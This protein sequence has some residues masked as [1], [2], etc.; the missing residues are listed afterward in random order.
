MGGKHTIRQTRSLSLLYLTQQ[1]GHTNGTA[2]MYDRVWCDL[3]MATS[4]A[5]N[6]T[7]YLTGALLCVACG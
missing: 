3:M 4:L 2:N 6:R 5:T 7:N 1:L